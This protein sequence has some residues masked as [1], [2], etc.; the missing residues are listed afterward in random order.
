MSATNFILFEA[1]IFMHNY[2]EHIYPTC[3][4]WQIPD[5]DESEISS[6]F[7][8]ILQGTVGTACSLS[9]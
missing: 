1:K 3:Q 4:T 8:W 9:H 5:I 2:L 7:L 6:V